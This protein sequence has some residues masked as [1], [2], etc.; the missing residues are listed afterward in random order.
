M[1]AA[2]EAPASPPEPSTHVGP[3]VCV[4]CAHPD[5]QIINDAL[6][7]GEPVRSVAARLNV[8]EPSLYRHKRAGHHLRSVKSDTSAPANGAPPADALAR[9]RASVLRD[10]RDHMRE[11]KRHLRATREAGDLKAANGALEAARKAY[12]S[13][14]EITG[15][16]QRGPRI[17]VN[18]TANAAA[19]AQREL[20]NAMS[21]PDV[22]EQAGAWLHAQLAAGAPEAVRTVR[23]LMRML[24]GAEV[25][26]GVALEHGE[27]DGDGR[28]RESEPSP[29]AAPTDA[30][31]SD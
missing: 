1:S 14:A 8:S 20:A 23:E 7:A 17:E 29:G 3:A 26:A 10:L 18:A 9:E 12:V 16:L 30:Y 13:V 2:L 15:E 21:A 4:S 27:G 19:V 6:C 24:P 25:A 28:A 11:C 5:A 22:T 31:A